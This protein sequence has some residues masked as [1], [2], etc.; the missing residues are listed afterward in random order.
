MLGKTFVAYRIVVVT[1]KGMWL[2]APLAFRNQHGGRDRGG[3][4]GERGGNDNRQR[5]RRFTAVAG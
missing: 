3:N 2:S 4:E 5:R 1:D